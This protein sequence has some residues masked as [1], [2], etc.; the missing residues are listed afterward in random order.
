MDL[1]I[2]TT[3]TSKLRE[4]RS[5][6]RELLP[7]V[8]IRSLLDFPHF[9]PETFHHASFGENAAAKALS[10][11]VALQMP[12]VA[13]ESGLVIPV[14]GGYQESLQRKQRQPSGKRLPD[15][16]QIFADLQHVEEADRSAF[17]ECALAFATPERVVKTVSA[18]MEGMIAPS[19]HGPA[20]FDFVSIFIKHEYNKTLA[21][22]PESV[23]SRISHRRKACEKL[24]PSLREFFSISRFRK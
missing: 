22:L 17:L 3:N 18:R 7:E 21:E 14:L 19:E 6:L 15:T 10:A 4:L 1:I 23:L 20:S 16:K 2:A 12:C 8:S 5:I 13:D 24:W 9:H 11:A